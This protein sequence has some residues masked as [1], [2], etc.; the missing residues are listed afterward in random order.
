MLADFFCDMLVTPANIGGR[1]LLHN[2]MVVCMGL[3]TTGKTLQFFLL[4]TKWQ[5]FCGK[6]IAILLLGKKEWQFF[7]LGKKRQFE[8]INTSTYTSTQHIST[9]T[10]SH[11]HSNTCQ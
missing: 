2:V 5:F 1:H 11:R 6:K 10:Q 4:G 9:S 8:V 7:F 3:L